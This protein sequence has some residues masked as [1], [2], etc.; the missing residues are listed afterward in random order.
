MSNTWGN[1]SSPTVTLHAEGA[2]DISEQYA[3]AA[4]GKQ[5]KTMEINLDSAKVNENGRVE[6]SVKATSQD[7][8]IQMSYI[9]IES[10]AAAP[11]VIPVEKIT[12]T[13]SASALEI[14]KTA[15]LKAIVEPADATDKNVIW[16]SSDEKIAVVSESGVVTAKGA[17]KATITATAADGSG[18]SGTY[19]VTV[20]KPA[21]EPKPVKVSKITLAGTISKLAA[22]KK[23]TL[24][25][26]VQP[27]NADNKKLSWKT[28]NP[29][30]AVVSGNGVVTA[31]GAGT[32]TITAT[33]ADGSGVKGTYKVSV[34]KHAVKKITLKSSSK[35]IAA[36]KKATVAAT[37]ATTG[38]T[39]NKALKWTV[40]NTK[41]AS[42]SS[43][44]LVTAKKAGAGK[45][46]TITAAATDGSGK[47]ASVTMKIVKDAVKKITLKCSKKTIAAGKKATIKATVSTTGRKDRKKSL[48]S[49]VST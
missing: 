38:K 44:G 48:K 20:V 15:E 6:L 43:K 18:V 31:K 47:K 40:S 13:G 21:V 12:V 29:K 24:K 16:K 30:V 25:A 32:A 19:L 39:A 5:E 27:S 7:P 35:A 46:V 28:S 8:T 3:V 10:E 33:A 9:I 37:V 1:A 41:Y 36:G 2:A 23:V 49:P 4:S 22:G 14:G 42:V 34:V 45:T 26:T 17:G 11:V